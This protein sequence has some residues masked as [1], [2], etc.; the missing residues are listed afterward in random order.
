[1]F[2]FAERHGW[3]R[4]PRLMLF[5][6]SLATA[7]LQLLLGWRMNQAESGDFIVGPL[8][9]VAI[10]LLMLGCVQSSVMTLL[11][12]IGVSTMGDYAYT[13]RAAGSAGYM[14]AVILMGAVGRTD[15]EIAQWHL[16]IGS[17]ISLGHA[18]LA[19]AAWLGL[20]A[21][22]AHQA[23]VD[24][25]KQVVE[26]QNHF[27][28]SSKRP[29]QEQASDRKSAASLQFKEARPTTNPRSDWIELLTIVWLVAIC[30]MSYGLYAHEFMT[31]TFGYLGYFVFSAAVAIEII[32]LLVMPFFPKLKAKLLFVGPLGWL[33]LFSGCILATL[34]FAPLGLFGLAL[35]LNCPFQISTN[36]HAHRINSSVMG[37]ASMTLAQSLGYVTATIIAS[38]AASFRAGPMLLWLLVLPLSMLAL[39][40]AVR[41]LA[42]Q[43]SAFDVDDLSEP[44]GV[45]GGRAISSAQKRPN[46]LESMLRAD[47]SGADAQDIHVVML[48][49]LPSGIG[50]VAKAGANPREL[51]G[52]NT[53]SNS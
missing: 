13:V 45:A 39:A 28:E 9:D 34:G 46:H 43:N 53:H 36:E 29:D 11:N 5:C 17:A 41:K 24:A 12:H 6:T 33:L 31:K 2:R 47:D 38:I 16:F 44:S 15:S 22:D 51:V 10:C 35:A 23:S 40:L 50:I 7:V 42:R 4:S 30:E 18:I 48:D 37:V 14:V 21:V 52:G 25:I 49:P 27:A 1:M 26:P 8:V 20:R 3:T 19:L 32:L